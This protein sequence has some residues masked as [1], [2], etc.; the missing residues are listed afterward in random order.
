MRRCLLAVFMLLAATSFTAVAAANH[1]P[2]QPCNGCVSHEHWPRID[3]VVMKAKFF[4][5]NFT[6]TGR[7]DELLGHIGSDTLRGGG[8]SD[9]LWGDWDRNNQ[10]PGQVDQ[11]FGGGGNDFIYAS[12]GQ[13]TIHAGSGND[14]ISGHYGS[15][16]IDC[17]PGRDI[18]HVP[19]SRRQGWRVRNCEKVDYRSERQRGGGLKPLT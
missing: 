13:N 1:I 4:P 8:G 7:S 2:G 3:G 9:V 19:R 6:G 11:I 5:A 16:L 18:Y 12:H 17:G 14:A 15:G 10:P